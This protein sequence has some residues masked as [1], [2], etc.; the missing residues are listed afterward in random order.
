M[1]TSTKYRLASPRLAL[2]RLVACLIWLCVLSFAAHAS[3]MR[4]E[5]NNG[6]P[7]VAGHLSMYL[8]RSGEMSFDQAVEHKASGGFIPVVGDEVA[9]GYINNSALWLHLTLERTGHTPTDWMLSFSQD[10]IDFI[11]LYIQ[12][13]SGAYSIKKGGRAMPSA[14]REFTFSGHAFR[15]APSTTTTTSM[16]QDVYVRL[17]TGVS[18]RFAVRVWQEKNFDRFQ[19]RDNFWV[20]MYFGAMSLVFLISLLRALKN[21]NL[22]D[23][24][25]TTYIGT[26]EGSNF[27]AYGYAQQL[28]GFD[29]WLV[30]I[31]L[32]QLGLA[33]AGLSLS[34]LLVVLIGWPQPIMRRVKIAAFGITLVYS[35][36]LLCALLVAPRTAPQ[37]ILAFSGL[38]ILYTL[39]LG[40][41]AARNGWAQGKAFLLAFSPFFVAAGVV[42]L[43]NFGVINGFYFTRDTMF[44]A[45]VFHAVFLYLAVFNRETELARAKEK[46]E[47]KV[48]QL[49]EELSDQALFLHM[50]THEVRTPLAV[51][52]SH[53]QLLSMQKLG[54]HSMLHWIDEIRT[55]V[56]HI[57]ELLNRCVAQFR[58]ATFKTIQKEPV[59]LAALLSLVASEVQRSTENH[60]ITCRIEKLPDAVT[61]DPDLFKILLSNLLEN[62]V[63][64]SPEGGVIEVVACVTKT[65]RIAIEVRDEGVGIPET[66]LEHIFQRYFRTQ[67]VTGAVGAGLGL[68]IVRSIARLHGGDVT[69][70]STLGEGSTFVVTLV[71]LTGGNSG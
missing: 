64:Y 49:G 10:L 18:M 23:T 50:L 45:T 4:L 47:W 46:L 48:S 55:G 58:L 56:A 65:G 41:W 37:W 63:K 35:L 59:N 25:Y 3:P 32:G 60:L 6:N 40:A 36:T 9:A 19:A 5:A 66:E 17:A 29:D 44:L 15:L 1:K 30:R 16:R 20:G 53:S 12:Q 21:R 38:L 26:L 68:Y 11:E 61:L 39:L 8:D 13:P 54:D 70:Q 57:A 69:C 67:Q 28:G 33:L 62:A 43:T 22:T 24:L 52:D 14:A 42:I 34:W 31:I 2:Q 27:L 51:I 7:S 71:P